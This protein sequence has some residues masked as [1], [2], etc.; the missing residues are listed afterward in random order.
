MVLRVGSGTWEHRTFADLPEL[1]SPG[2]VLVLNNTRVVPARVFGHR[3][4]TGGKWEG[5]F[6]RALADGSW[7]MLATTQG[8]PASRASRSPSR[9]ACG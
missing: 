2:D 1:L 6:L 3:E 7:E 9:G 5:L 8:P 4:A